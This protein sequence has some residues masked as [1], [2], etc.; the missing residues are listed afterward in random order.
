MW[1]DAADLDTLPYDATS[2][3]RGVGGVTTTGE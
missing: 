1:R 2:Q 3:C